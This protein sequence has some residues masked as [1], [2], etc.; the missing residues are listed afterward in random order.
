MKLDPHIYEMV[1]YEYLK[2]DSQGFLNLVKEWSPDLYNTSAVINAVLEH[3]LICDSDKEIYLESLALLYSYEKKYDKSLS[4]YLKLKHKGVFVLI[5]QHNLYSVIH[6]MIIDLMALDSE[7][8]IAL[9]LEN[10]IPAEI[11]V[12]KLKDHEELLYRV[13]YTSHRAECR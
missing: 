1:L 9:L 12:D 7:K 5:Q 13:R 2:L 8:A 11:V 6:D 3:L 4:M 10:K